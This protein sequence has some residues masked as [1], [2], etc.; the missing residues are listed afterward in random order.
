[1]HKELRQLFRYSLL[2]C[3]MCI[4]FRLK[5]V[6]FFSGKD[7]LACVNKKQLMRLLNSF[8]TSPLNTEHVSGCKNVVLVDY[9]PV[10]AWTLVN[11]IIINE[12]CTISNSIPL[13]LNFTKPS[14]QGK[15]FFESLGLSV[16]TRFDFGLTQVPKLYKLYIE[17]LFGMKDKTAVLD[18]KIDEINI[19]LDVYETYLKLGHP[20]IDLSDHAFKKVLFQ[21][22]VQLLTLEKLNRRH[23][24]TAVFASHENFIGPGLL[25]KYAFRYEIPVILANVF[26][27]N[28]PEKTF[29]NHERYSRYPLYFDSLSEQ[30]QEQGLQ[31]ARIALEKRISGEIRVNM[32]YQESSAYHN[33]IIISQLKPSK[34]KK[35]LIST[36]DF[37]DNPH[38]YSRLSYPD[39]FEWLEFLGNFSRENRD[40]E[41][42]IKVHRDR[43]PIEEQITLEFLNR[44]S[45]ISWVDPEV[46]FHQLAQEGLSVAITCHGSI[47]HELPLLGVPVLNCAYNPHIAYDFNLHALSI[48]E[49]RPKFY[50]C[51]YSRTKIDE[52]QLYEFYYVHNFMNQPNNFNIDDFAEFDS[53]TNR[54]QNHLDSISYLVERYTLI[55]KKIL[56]NLKNSIGTRTMYSIELRLSEELRK[57]NNT[58]GLKSL[59]NLAGD[60]SENSSR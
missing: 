19:G 14:F 22:M 23:E 51:I 1:M 46:S 12:I 36:H 10:P 56:K 57:L 25:T 30:D 42:Y 39:F 43:S 33:K 11:S 38:A 29:D 49:F 7:L 59:A 15:I 41:W 37:F 60:L 21:S 58:Q 32:S 13:V 4:W 52:K 47:G 17:A 28:F 26:E 45:H 44:Y 9:F 31:I 18:Y 40:L 5:Q 6:S 16:F 8:N 53:F 24:I 27:I 48:Q 54:Q 20:T 3:Y 2:F 50:D 34:S 55:Q 35:V